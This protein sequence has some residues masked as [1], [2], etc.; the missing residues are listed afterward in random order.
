MRSKSKKRL[1]IA[2]LKLSKPFFS[3]IFP[4]YN[5]ERYL[6]ASLDSILFQTFQDFEIIAINDGSTDG[7]LN[8]LEE[9]SKNHCNITLISQKNGGLSHARN[10]GMKHASGEYLCFVDSDDVLHPNYL[11]DFYNVISKTQAN[12]CKN[13]NV[14]KFST[15]PPQ[16][17]NIQIQNIHQFTFDNLKIGCNVWTFAFKHSLIAKNQISF[18]EGRIFEDEPFVFMILPLSSEIFLFEGSPYL[19]RQ[20]SQSIVAKSPVAFDR[21]ENFKDIIE[22]YQAKNLLGVCPIPFYILYDVSINNPHYLEYLQASQTTLRQLP[23][24]PYLAQDSLANALYHLPIKD[25]VREHQKS[26]G[27][28]KYYLRRLF[29]LL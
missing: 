12:I 22:W 19:Y 26:R 9:Y 3:I 6:S 17:S 5:V 10:T 15:T 21:I 14:V 11:D 24:T 29:G 16:M 7:S 23:L 2:D 13:T 4:V 1:K 28:L 8:I 20:H 27:K 25:F 18:L